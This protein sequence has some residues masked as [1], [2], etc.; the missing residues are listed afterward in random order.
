M[1]RKKAPSKKTSAKKR[2]VK[3]KTVKKTIRKKTPIRKKSP[4]RKK[5]TGK[6]KSGVGRHFKRL[7]LMAATL[8]LTVLF[9]YSLYLSQIVMV[10]FEG[11]RW[12]VPARVYARSMEL[13]S[14][15]DISKNQLQ[16][17][18]MRL[19][20]RRQQQPGAPGTWQRTDNSFVI[21]TRPFDFW[22]EQVD[23]LALRV[24]F[25]GNQLNNIKN[26]RSGS[27]EAI[28]RLES[29]M[30]DS[31]Y[32][33][34]NEDR[35]LVRY[36]DIPALM[37]DTLVAVE[38]RNFFAH[39][40]VSIK[41][42]ARAFI[43]NMRAG[44]VV[45]GGSTLTQ[46][47][48]KNFFLSSERTLTR[49]LNEALMALIVDWHYDKT[50]ILEAYA[51]EI[52][53]GQDGKR[54]IHGFGLASRFYFNRPLAELD[55]SRI[56]LLIGMIKG[57]SYYDPRRNPK[58]ALKRRNLVLDLM[59][60][61]GLLTNKRWQLA[62][63]RSL[64]LAS[65]KHG[66]QRGYP[67]FIKLVRQQLK[68]DY[69]EEDLTS[70][71]LRIFTTLD[72]WV[73]EQ[74]ESKARVSLSQLENRHKL[75]AGRLQVAA[76]IANVSN[77]E[78]LGVVGGRNASQSGFNRALDAVRPIGSLVKPLVFLTALMRP[79]EYSLITQIADESVSIKLPN[80]DL[81]QPQ[82]YDKQSHGQVPLINALASSYNQATVNLGM[83]LGLTEVIDTLHKAGVKRDIPA[84]PSLLLGSLSLS[85]MEVTQ[86]Y[87]SLG[88]GGFYS[89]L[90]A[91]HEVLD[92]DNK[93]L[94]RYPLTV[95]QTLP[96]TP[97][98]LL[99]VALQRVVNT[100]TARALRSLVGKNAAFAGKTGT[101]NDL[102]DSWFAGF[103][104]K[105][106][107]AVWVGRDDNSEAGL[108]GAQGAMRVWA[109]IFSSINTE[110]LKLNPT[111]GVEWLLIDDQNG[112]LA[113]ERCESA[114]KVPFIKGYGPSR[115][116][117][118]INKN[119]NLFERLFD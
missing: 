1:T 50:E 21:Y 43:A 85:P 2:P 66:G 70:E 9:F 61:Q 101:T 45:Q 31:I 77:G 106:V 44:Q 69:R 79:D 5:T 10:K 55:E 54:A 51:N 29:P 116:S 14:G 49:K 87:Q 109:K 25:S 58:R 39:H 52:Y 62:K 8:S 114:V 53:L 112:L 98:Y 110:S 57:P 27:E 28:V 82:N 33:S 88:N 113:S 7:V 73:Q 93:P 32:P 91:I 68:R 36:D 60:E 83:A 104:D 34:H 64:G 42:I 105:H 16:A 30:V 75:Q 84:Y 17:E 103:S 97:V 90:R 108:T 24:N 81:W 48:V 15:A 13:Y 67:A 37:K 72:P 111:S 80:G 19:G 102:R 107:A 35:I 78:V 74:A 11:K 118:C 40:G 46:Q 56:A 22:D 115:E 95:K 23:E 6:A 26:L 92:N 59:L 20:Y 94:Q 96:E 119:R 63:N 76:V 18:L 12:A 38:D 89:P 65:K 100:G 4:V 71:G 41:S 99:N 3:K 86:I 47:L 117:P